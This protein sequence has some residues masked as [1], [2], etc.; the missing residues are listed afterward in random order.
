MSYL[1]LLLFKDRHEH[2]DGQK[3][4]EHQKDEARQEQ[5]RCSEWRAQKA[6]SVGMGKTSL[7]TV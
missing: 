7:F 6:D 3:C 2:D 1:F 5:P 4:D